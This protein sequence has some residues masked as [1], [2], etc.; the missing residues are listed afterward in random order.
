MG[1]LKGRG[2]EW[3]RVRG[4]GRRVTKWDKAVRRVCIIVGVRV[5]AESAGCVLDGSGGGWGGREG[6]E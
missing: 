5:R 3:V 4:A 6:R 1:P 2:R